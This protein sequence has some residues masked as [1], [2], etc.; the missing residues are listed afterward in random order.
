MIGE[1]YKGHMSGL[2]SL[3]SFDMES[4]GLSSHPQQMAGHGGRTQYPSSYGSVDAVRLPQQRQPYLPQQGQLFAPQPSQPFA[5]H[6]HQ[7]IPSSHSSYNIHNS[8]TAHQASQT[9]NGYGQGLAPVSFSNHSN[10]HGPTYISNDWAQ[11]SLTYPLSN[12]NGTFTIP[13][14]GYNM[15]DFTSNG[16]MTSGYSGTSVPPQSRSNKLMKHARTPTMDVQS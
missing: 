14:G 2:D 3:P 8:R 5:P 15:H 6:Q 1:R 11:A 12:P 10:L 7:A 4:F 9:S 16:P 13:V